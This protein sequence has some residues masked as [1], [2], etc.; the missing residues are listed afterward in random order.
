MDGR[1]KNGGARIGA[2]GL[3]YAKVDY[4]RSE[5]KRLSPLWFE[6]SEKWIKGKDKRL[7]MLAYQELGKLMNKSMPTEITGE[8]GTPI[9]IKVIS[10]AA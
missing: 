10:Y 6:L 7:K 1:A 2:G 8:D 9:E 4:I 5:V 3:S